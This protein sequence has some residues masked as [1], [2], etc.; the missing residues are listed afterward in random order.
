[1]W[2][3]RRGTS[4]LH[5]RADESM[6][7]LARRTMANVQGVR[8]LHGRCPGLIDDEVSDAEAAGA[9]SAGT[10]GQGAIRTR[11]EPQRRLR[12]AQRGENNGAACA[13]AAA[14]VTIA[15]VAPELMIT[16]PTALPLILRV[17]SRK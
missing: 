7:A 6:S 5:E 16:E 10:D 11:T 14:L 15:L 9:G 4:S 8:G 3:R 2:A 12:V 17:P 13:V 1:G